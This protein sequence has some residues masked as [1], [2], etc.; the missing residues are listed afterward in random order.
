M[1]GT[2]QQDGVCNITVCNKPY[3]PRMQN[4]H[5]Y[6][7]QETIKIPSK[8]LMKEKNDSTPHFIPKLGVKWD[9]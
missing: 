8:S 4:L 3:V 7:S 2:R 5:T 1:D 6:W 9:P